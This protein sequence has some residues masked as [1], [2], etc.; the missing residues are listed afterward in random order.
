MNCI[1]CGDKLYEAVINSKLHKQYGFKYSIIDY[2]KA[3]FTFSGDTAYRFSYCL[4]NRSYS[5]FVVTKHGFYCY[6]CFKLFTNNKPI[7]NNNK[8]I[9]GINIRFDIKYD[10]SSKS[11]FSRIKANKY[12][13]ISR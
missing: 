8:S 9:Y 10:K 6:N 4:K 5:S 12:S 2:F 13:K 3:H 7:K 11:K 1:Y